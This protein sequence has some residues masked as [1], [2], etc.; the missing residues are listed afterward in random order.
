MKLNYTVIP[1]LGLASFSCDKV[2][3]LATQAKSAVEKHVTNSSGG[4]TADPE[5]QKLVD[6][7]PDGAIFRK[8]LAFPKNVAVTYTR[9]DEL[10]THFAQKSELGSLTT[11]ANGTLR[12]VCKL[13]RK[14]DAL[15]Y[16]YHE[17][18]HE[19]SAETKEDAKEA[20]DNPVIPP[21]E[22][23]VFVKSGTAWKPANRSDFKTA[24]L[25]RE[26]A[27]VLDEL[28]VDNGLAPRTQWF[29]RHRV[30]I[31]DS[32]NVSGPT[33]PMIFPGNATGSLKLT[34]ESFGAVHGH[35]CGVFAISGNY[36]RKQFP[37][38]HGSL[39]DNEATIQ[40]GKIWLSL[41]YPIVLRMETELIQ[42]ERVSGQGGLATV[43]QGSVKVSLDRDWKKSGP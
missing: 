1:L 25:C 37:G 23:S 18:T 3:D 13:E 26:L 39:T 14:G 34:L 42:T 5:L 32:L 21:S 24:M 20:D 8:D 43:S 33:L 17:F 40:S 12:V 36:S 4:T 6:L 35:P 31:G 16:T 27:P 7:T 10:S 29:G 30:K 28:L 11:P 38:L 19:K 2:K 22:P 9:K 15:D 41:L